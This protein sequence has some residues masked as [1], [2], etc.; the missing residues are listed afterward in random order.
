MENENRHGLK[1]GGCLFVC[2]FIFS[3]NPVLPVPRIA[4]LMQGTLPARL[5]CAGYKAL[6]GRGAK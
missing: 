1:P 3:G 5:N 4:V 2:A 6:L